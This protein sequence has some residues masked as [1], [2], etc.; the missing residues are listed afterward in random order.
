MNILNSLNN[1]R[2]QVSKNNTN[3]SHNRIWI[4]RNHLVPKVCPKEEILIPKKVM[5]HQLI[6]NMY[7]VLQCSKQEKW[8]DHALPKH[9]LDKIMFWLKLENASNKF[10]RN[11]IKIKLT[12]LKIKTLYKIFLM[13]EQIIWIIIQQIIARK[14]KSTKE[15]EIH[16]SNSKHNPKFVKIFRKMIKNKNQQSTIFYYRLI[17]I[18][19]QM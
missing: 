5:S 1:Q 2:Q 18:K 8:R 4:N 9:L 10:Q 19:E 12:N 14:C 13:L 17:I 7:R 6:Y 16:I 15:V 3:L 11:K